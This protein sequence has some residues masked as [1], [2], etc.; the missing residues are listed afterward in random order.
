[1]LSL[2]ILLT[3]LGFYCCYSTSKRAMLPKGNPVVL[4][5]SSN[6]KTS[7]YLGLFLLTLSLIL[8]VINQALLDGRVRHELLRFA[9]FEGREAVRKEP[10]LERRH[11]KFEGVAALGLLLE[12]REHDAAHDDREAR[13]LEDRRRLAVEER[14]DDRAHDRLAGLDDLAEERVAAQGKYR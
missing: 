6:A 3:A 14:V 13:R 7:K 11:V 4:W 2:S 8:C 5:A 1:M 12:G 9:T 10:E